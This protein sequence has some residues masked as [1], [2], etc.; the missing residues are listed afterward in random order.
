MGL[1]TETL[2]RWSDTE[3]DTVVREKHNEARAPLD[4]PA[5]T[6]GNTTGTAAV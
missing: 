5:N 1:V 2:T 3:S 6:T 4:A